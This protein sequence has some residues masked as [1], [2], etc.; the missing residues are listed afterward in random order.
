MLY[1]QRWQKTFL[2]YLQRVS[3]GQAASYEF[4]TMFNQTTNLKRD[5]I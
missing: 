5:E 4:E 1:G 2:Q 3:K